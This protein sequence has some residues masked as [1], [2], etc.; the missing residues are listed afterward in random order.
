VLLIDD[1][2]GTLEPLEMQFERAF[3]IRA[4]AGG[5]ECRDERETRTVLRRWPLR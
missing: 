1:A 3:A 4:A 2:P 5:D